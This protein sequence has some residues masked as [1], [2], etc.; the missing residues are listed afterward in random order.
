MPSFEVAK[1]CSTRMPVESKKAGLALSFW[2]VSVAVLP[3]DK[4]SGVR[5][6]V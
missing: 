5:K 6:S 3:R 4:V 2:S 1:R